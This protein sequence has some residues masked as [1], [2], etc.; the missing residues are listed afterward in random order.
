VY[1]PMA[2]YLWSGGLHCNVVASVKLSDRHNVVVRVT[3]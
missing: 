1:R 2:D 3:P